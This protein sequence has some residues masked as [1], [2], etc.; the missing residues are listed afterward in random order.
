[1]HGFNPVVAANAIDSDY[2]RYLKT[3]FNP[4]RA[5]FASLYAAA[6]GEATETGELGGKLHLQPRR[7]YLEGKTIPELINEG[8][9]HPDMAGM[10]AHPL[11][12]HQ[13]EAVRLAASSNIVLATGTGSGKT[14]GF[15]LPIINDLL[16]ERD[17]GT[18]EDDGVRAIIVYPMNALAADQ[19]KR[20]NALLEP[21]KSITYGRFVGPT[22]H[23]QS[24]AERKWKAQPD[25]GELPTHELMS[26]DV[27]R[28]TPPHILVTNYAML[29]RLLL[30][31]E[32]Y[33]F[34]TPSLKA[35]A[36]DEVHVYDGAKGTEIAML[37]RRLQSRSGKG[38]T[39]VRCY[40]ASATLGDGSASSR[41]EAAKFASDLFG[42]PFTSNG[43]IL[44]SHSVAQPPLGTT[45]PEMLALYKEVNENRVV[46]AS[47]PN[48]SEERRVGKEC[49]V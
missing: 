16:K 35:I 8:I 34:F 38:S 9:L 15:L 43:V 12:E 21:L 3:T 31:P 37:L 17:A 39:A 49:P 42:A 46:D 27:M 23:S 25:A 5:W 29:E 4:R 1:M 41:E 26:R 47:L 48:R 33:K 28:K 10:L 7:P 30:L 45:D 32:N 40:A 36:L 14:E 6:L 24:E 18:L 22:P 44:P 11:Y 20:L 19:M 2:K 13:E